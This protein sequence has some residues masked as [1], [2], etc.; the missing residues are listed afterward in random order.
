MQE[1]LDTASSYYIRLNAKYLVPIAQKLAMVNLKTTKKQTVFTLFIFCQ[2]RNM[3]YTDFQQP[4]QSVQAVE[5]RKV[6]KGLA[7]PENNRQLLIVDMSVKARKHKFKCVF[8]LV[9]TFQV[10]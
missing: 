5:I 8:W 6:K 1:L 7:S 3:Y 9:S 10:V 4:C 2:I